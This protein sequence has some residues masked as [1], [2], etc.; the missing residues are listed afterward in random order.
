MKTDTVSN[1]IWKEGTTACQAIEQLTGKP[2]DDAFTSRLV[3]RA[4]HEKHQNEMHSMS[5][6]VLATADHPVYY[7]AMA[8]DGSLYDAHGAHTPIEVR[9]SQRIGPHPVETTKLLLS[10]DEG[11]TFK[12]E[13]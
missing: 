6:L 9:Y 10:P 1:A 5:P 8:S 2:I 11:K 12:I 7:Y 13:L 3:A 4:I